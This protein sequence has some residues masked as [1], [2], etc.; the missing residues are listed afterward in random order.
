MRIAETQVLAA[1]LKTHGYKV[2]SLHPGMPESDMVRAP[3]T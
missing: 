1:E 3:H 2:V